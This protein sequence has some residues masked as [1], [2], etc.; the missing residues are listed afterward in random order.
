MQTHTANDLELYSGM[1]GANAAATEISKAINEAQAQITSRLDGIDVGR[2]WNDAGMGRAAKIVGE[3]YHETV[4]PV[5][6]KHSD[7]GACDTEPRYHATQALIDAAK[8]KLDLVGYY[9]E[10]GDWI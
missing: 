9:S 1:A 7:F 3:V 6:K 5:L 2:G 4:Y 8:D 10:L